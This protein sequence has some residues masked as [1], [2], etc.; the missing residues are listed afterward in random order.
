MCYFVLKDNGKVLSWLTVQPILKEELHTDQ[1]LTKKKI[2]D[3]ELNP[4]LNNPNFI[5]ANT[6]PLKNMVG[7]HTQRNA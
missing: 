2:F 5:I 7:Y 3:D 4:I 6:S 1:F